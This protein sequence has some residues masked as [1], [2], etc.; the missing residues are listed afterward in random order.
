MK[1]KFAGKA[2]PNERAVAKALAESKGR[3]ATS[4]DVQRVSIRVYDGAEL[5]G[6]WFFQRDGFGDRIIREDA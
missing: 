6:E 4:Y 3:N 2:Y 5:L 1:W